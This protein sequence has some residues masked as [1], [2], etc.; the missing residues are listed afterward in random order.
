MRHH[1]LDTKTKHITRKLQASIPYKCGCKDPHQNTSKLN[2]T[3]S[4][5]DS[6]PC[7]AGFIPG[8]LHSF[9]I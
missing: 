2:P 4:K 3:P 5:K 6:T 9:N 8:I 1:Y 7:Q